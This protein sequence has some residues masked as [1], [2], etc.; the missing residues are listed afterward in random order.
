M[1][2]ALCCVV[3]S[4]ALLL[5]YIPDLYTTYRVEKGLE[6]PGPDFINTLLDGVRA[7]GLVVVLVCESK[8]IQDNLSMEMP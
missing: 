7:D 2:F 6:F 5:I 4:A 3:T 8:G 1:V